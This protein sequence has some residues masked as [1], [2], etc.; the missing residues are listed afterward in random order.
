MLYQTTV[1]SSST[2][3]I[4]RE[5]CAL[6]RSPGPLRAIIRL[7]PW[8]ALGSWLAL[9]AVSHSLTTTSP[10]DKT[11]GHLPG[12]KFTSLRANLLAG[13]Q[14]LLRV[15][16]LVWP[17]HWSVYQSGPVGRSALYCSEPES[18]RVCWEYS[19]GAHW[20]DRNL[21][22]RSVARPE[23]KARPR[24]SS[25][26]RNSPKTPPHFLR[27]RSYETRWLSTNDPV[28][29]TCSVEPRA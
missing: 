1:G 6:E 23:N 28:V 19:N 24:P 8:A 14:V 25:S 12:Q 4:F 15:P 11:S 7:M 13:R 21:P 20:P 17:V 22:G 5:G 18:L 16:T 29:Q 26:Q 2:D 3:Y 10:L 27:F 9:P